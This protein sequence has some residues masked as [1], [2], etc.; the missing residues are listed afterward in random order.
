MSGIINKVK[1]AV[2]HHQK[3]DVD[4]RTDNNTFN[5]NARSS[6]HGPHASNVANE[7]DPRVDSDRSN[8]AGSTGGSTGYGSQSTNHG[9]HDSNIANKADPRV[10]SDLDNTRTSH[11]G[12]TTGATTGSSL[13]EPTT[14]GYGS[15]STNYGPHDSNIAN[16]ADP[17]VDSDLDN[18]R[19]SHSQSAAPGIA[20][21][22][23]TATGAGRESLQQS[24]TTG[25]ASSTAGPHDSNVA[26]KADP[27]V[28][29]DLDS[30]QR[31]STSGTTNT[32][33]DSL[34]ESRMTGPASSTAG[35]H[36]SNV[37]NKADPRVDS[38]LDN[39]HHYEKEVRKDS[40][41]GTAGEMDGDFSNG[42]TS[43]KTFE[44]AQ[45][46]GAAGAGAGTGSSY[47]NPSSRSTAGPHDSNVANKLDPRVD[48]DRDGS[49]TIGN[50]RA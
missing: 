9:P 17:R 45:H 37:A 34:Q 21:G 35:P 23:A 13:N 50:Q 38:D 28:D 22:G 8:V 49:T 2:S 43:T 3:D 33:R 42:P 18:T 6:N 24:R 20:A 25:P 47:N 41:L 44:E 30:T 27:R 16:K 39:T 29:S 46:A 5:E 11:T 10:D 19:T 4:D 32:G 40:L 36:K 15:Q 26:N 48:S 14:R 31:N 7:A 1:D 12:A